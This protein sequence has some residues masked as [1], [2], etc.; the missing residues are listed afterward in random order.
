MKNNSKDIDSHLI[1]KVKNGN[2]KAFKIA[3]NSSSK[4]L[5]NQK[6]GGV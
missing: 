2:E 3:I 4:T 1:E 5:K 6:K